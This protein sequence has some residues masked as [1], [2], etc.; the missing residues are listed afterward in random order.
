MPISGDEELE[1][2]AAIASEKLQEIQDHLDRRD[3]NKLGRI[4]FP[5]GYLRECPRA[6]Y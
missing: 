5:R 6:K 4:E 3:P 1:Q 2:A